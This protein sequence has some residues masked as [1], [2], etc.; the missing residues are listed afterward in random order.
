M[1]S[2]LSLRYFDS[3]IKPLARLPPPDSTEI[4]TLSP[5]H[6]EILHRRGRKRKPA[7]ELKIPAASCRESSTVRN[8]LAF[9]VQPLDGAGRMIPPGDQQSIPIVSQPPQKT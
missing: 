3:I 8:A 7:G 4:M 6:P 1:F 5:H 2:M 9:A